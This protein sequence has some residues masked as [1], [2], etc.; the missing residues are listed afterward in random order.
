MRTKEKALEVLAAEYANP[1]GEGWRVHEKLEEEWGVKITLEDLATDPF[2][3]H[4]R[5]FLKIL[6]PPPGSLRPLY[7]DLEVEPEIA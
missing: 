5:R 7:K 2:Q 1:R 6:K 4:L 3:A